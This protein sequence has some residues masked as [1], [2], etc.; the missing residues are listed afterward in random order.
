MKQKRR[1]SKGKEIRPTFFIFCEG[2]TEELYVKYLRSLYRIPVEIDS[3]IAGNRITAK[4]ISNYKQQMTTHPKD[5]TFLIYD[6]DVPDIITKL[7]KIS[8]IK[9]LLSNPCFELWYL[10]H[11]HNQTAE[12]KTTD[13]IKKLSDHIRDYAKG[14]FD[15]NLEKKIV[16]NKAIA[17]SRAKN[18][19]EFNNPSTNVYALLE[20][21][22]EIKI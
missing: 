2:E 18:L 14:N 4:Y 11:C 15:K 10:L 12:L 13:C 3:K 6:Y 22:D 1:Q 7:Q 16:D 9:L 17:I 5:K 20:E 21:L 19:V 8:G